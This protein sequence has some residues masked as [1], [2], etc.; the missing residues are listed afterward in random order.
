MALDISKELTLLVE[1]ADN[2]HKKLRS[3]IQLLS[4]FL[5]LESGYTL[6]NLSREA[7]EENIK[8][9]E[10]ATRSMQDE[11]AVKLL[12]IIMLVYLPATIVLNFFSTE[13]ITKTR[14]PDG[15]AITSVDHDWTIVLV[16]SVPL[17]AGTLGIWWLWTQVQSG[18]LQN[19]WARVRQWANEK[20]SNATSACAC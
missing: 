14:L 17:T 9:E 11:A 4:S 6:Q 7:Q 3:S 19:R 1:Q 13:F 18:A 5:D 8:M 12:T 10:I 20:N 15:S 16:I 2:L